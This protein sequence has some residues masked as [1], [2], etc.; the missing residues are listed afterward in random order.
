MFNNHTRMTKLGNLW[1][2]CHVS[3]LQADSQS[4]RNFESMPG[5]GEKLQRRVWISL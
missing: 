1:C 3:G 4:R 2:V 5:P